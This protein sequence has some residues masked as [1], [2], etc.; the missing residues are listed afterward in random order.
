MVHHS[1]PE[2]EHAED[3]IKISHESAGARAT[4]AVR[5]VAL[6]RRRT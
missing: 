2:N 4:R 1:H 6:C 3:I 5:A